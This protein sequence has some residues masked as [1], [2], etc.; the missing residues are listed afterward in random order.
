MLPVYPESEKTLE[1]TL[2]KAHYIGNNRERCTMVSLGQK[3]GLIFLLIFVFAGAVCHAAVDLA[4]DSSAVVSSAN[5]N[6]AIEGNDCV[7]LNITLINNGDVTATNV[8]AT[9]FSTDPNIG[10]VSASATKAY[11]DIPATGT[12]T[13]ATPFTIS[14]IPAFLCGDPV[15]LTLEVTTDQGDFTIPISLTSG[16]VPTE[17]SFLKTGAVKIR[18][19]KGQATSS[20]SGVAG[21]TTIDD[22]RVA[23]RIT[24]PFDGDLRLQ[25][26][27]PDN[28]TVTLS[29]SNGGSGDDYGTGAD[30]SDINT[31]TIFDDDAVNPITGG[32]APFVGSFIPQNAMTPYIGKTGAAANGTWRLRVRDSVKANPGDGFIECWVLLVTSTPACDTTGGTCAGNTTPQAADDSYPATMDT[33]L[34]IAA[35]GVLTNDTDQENDTL[36]ATKL[37]DPAHGTVTLNGD[38]SF[39]YDPTTGYTGP[40]SFTYEASDAGGDS[41][42]ATVSINVTSGTPPCTFFCEDFEAGTSLPAGWV[43]GSGTW[44]VVTV[45]AANEAQGTT[46]STGKASLSS[47]TVTAPADRTV[48]ANVRVLKTTSRVTLKGWKVDSK[49]FVKVTLAADTNQII[50]TQKNGTQIATQTASQ[51]IGL[52]THNI[53]VSF[54][55]VSTIT[56]IVD[57]GTPVNLT[58]IATPAGD[59]GFAV[60]SMNTSKA[61]GGFLDIYVY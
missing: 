18:S 55:G 3:S 22:I 41:N 7:D 46:S 6:L 45:T 10:V 42:E 2:Y 47:P 23:V 36:T 35:P 15:D 43:V 58:T 59:V 12:A 8:S 33:Q 48:E 20:L 39:D 49:H 28:T 1:F 34:N 54:D 60:K 4:F 57:A 40:D 56:A 50:V 16:P 25:L 61:K 19:G 24:H 31:L 32:A 17:D 38:G 11:S 13:N 53:K 52:G 26:I 27:G 14:L 51:A 30:C 21:I 29:Q 44:S 37:T 9:L 5:G